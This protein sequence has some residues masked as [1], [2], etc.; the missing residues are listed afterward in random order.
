MVENLVAVDGAP[1]EVP[2][3]FSEI[4]RSEVATE[5]VGGRAASKDVEFIALD[6]ASLSVT[7]SA[8]SRFGW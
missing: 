6:R 7:T 5:M 4:W 2:D 8:F 3:A 1:A